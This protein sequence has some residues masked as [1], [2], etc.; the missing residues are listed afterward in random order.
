MASAFIIAAITGLFLANYHSSNNRQKLIMAA[1][2]L[3]SN[4]RLAQSY[5]ISAKEFNGSAPAGGWGV[6]CSLFSLNNSCIIFADVNGDKNYN[7]LGSEDFQK[8]YLPGDISIIPS[9]CTGFFGQTTIFFIPPDPETYLTVDFVTQKNQI[10][11]I[12]SNQG[13]AN[14]KVIEVN[15]IGLV[16]VRDY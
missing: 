9:D 8:I 4:I 15:P 10:C 1:Q 6:H 14:M 3:T 11:V 2:E 13:F 16:D 5:A 7:A 12:L